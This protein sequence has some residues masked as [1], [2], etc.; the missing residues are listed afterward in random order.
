MDNS[1]FCE[2]CKCLREGDAKY[3]TECGAKLRLIGKETLPLDEVNCENICKF[4]VDVLG[5]KGASWYEERSI[6]AKY[7]TDSHSPKGR[8]LL[9]TPEDVLFIDVEDDHICIS[10]LF[11]LRKDPS[12]DIQ[13]F[14][15]LSAL[16]GINNSDLIFSYKE[17]E[18]VDEI[19]QGENLE[20]L[21]RADINGRLKLS[22]K[23]PY[24][25]NLHLIHLYRLFRGGFERSIFH[26]ISLCKID[27]LFEHYFEL[28]TMH[29]YAPK[30]M[31]RTFG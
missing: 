12:N 8:E 4:L 26:K 22:K 3:C 30:N 29:I 13:F 10:A 1:A 31:H 14:K 21:S 9:S 24:I 17:P 2:S 25:P 11:E 6:I 20:K 28:K 19:E 16:N 5:Y 7:E 23:I 15:L 27:P 18:E